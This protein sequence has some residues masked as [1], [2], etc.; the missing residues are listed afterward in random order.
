MALADLSST[1][2]TCGVSDIKTFAFEIFWKPRLLVYL[3]TDGNGAFRMI[4]LS[5]R[6]AIAHFHRFS[7]SMQ[8]FKHALVDA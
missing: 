3:R 5:V 8:R 1:V 4:S 6:D 2:N 7:V